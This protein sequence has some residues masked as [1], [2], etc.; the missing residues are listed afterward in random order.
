MSF[1]VTQATKIFEYMTQ[2]AF[3]NVLEIFV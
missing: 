3:T 2:K 1:P